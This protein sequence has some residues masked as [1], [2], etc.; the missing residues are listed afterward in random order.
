MDQP[1]PTYNS[2]T[3]KDLAHLDKQIKTLTKFQVLSTKA[4]VCDY[5][6]LEKYLKARNPFR[7]VRHY[8]QGIMV[9]DD[10]TSAVDLIILRLVTNLYE[11]LH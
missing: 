8:V 10:G 1:S 3:S 2:L 11:N 9:Q 5:I 6:Q 4:L 7:G